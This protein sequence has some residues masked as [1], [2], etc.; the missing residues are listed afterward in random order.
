MLLLESS[1]GVPYSSFQLFGFSPQIWYL[2]DKV[3]KIISFSHYS[4]LVCLVQ[5]FQFLLSCTKTETRLHVI[6]INLC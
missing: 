4:L 5:T 3:L 6:Y 1:R 2:Q